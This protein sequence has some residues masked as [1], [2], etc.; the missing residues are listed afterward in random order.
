MEITRLF[1]ILP[2]YEES[3]QPKD[4]VLAG[5][6]NGV[7]KKYSISEFRK[8]VDSLSYAFLKLGIKKGVHIATVT[9]N[10]PEW[11]FVDMAAMQVGAVHVPIYPTI[12]LSD[13]E[14]ILNHAEIQYI[15][16]SGTAMYKKIEPVISKMES[17]KGIYIFND[18]EGLHSW[19]ELLKMGEENRCP[20]ELELVKS[21]ISTDD[22]ATMIYTSGTTG[23]QKGVMLSHRGLITNVKGV[24]DIPDFGDGHRA[25]SLLPLSHIY[26]RMM[27]CLYL[28]LGMS[29]YYAESIAKFVANCQEI[30]PSIMCCV[31]RVIESV[32][33]GLIQQGKKLTGTKKRLFDWALSV[34]E[35]YE[36]NENNSWLYEQSWKVAYR[37]VLSKLRDTLGGNF[38]LVVSGGSALNP[39]LLRIFHAAQVPIHEGYGLTETSPVIAVTGRLPEGIKVGSVGNVLRGVE[40]KISN[41][42]EI[43]SRGTNMMIG[44]FK[45][46]ELTKM[47]IDN[48]GWFHT[49]DCGRIDKDGFLFITGRIKDTFKTSNGKWI[50]PEL[51]ENKLTTSLYIDYA[52]VFGENQKMPGAL[53]IPNFNQLKMWCQ[54]NG[55]HFESREQVV[56]N[57]RVYDLIKREIIDINKQL[58][59][60]EQVGPFLLL[61]DEWSVISGELS[62][63]LKIKHALIAKRYA[64][65]IRKMF[66]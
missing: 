43:L 8:N 38:R 5:K 4:D 18:E 48:D 33:N 57:K 56:N 22:V 52:V 60:H 20:E 3:F 55:V 9:N 17:L 30:Q 7:W 24:A 25:L 11:N 13:Y 37:V 16:L 46:P 51:I 47:V 29:I 36:P 66:E 15:F 63:S 40:M 19:K 26:E 42:G 1:D 44:Y 12:S 2:Y 50:S 32:Y 65:Q 6:E 27:N 54:Q 14:Y 49:G 23:T 21:S 41:S 61:A 53:I 35:Q 58:G 62:A 28:Y 10:R 39:K 59:N 64:V 45:E 34:A 31:P